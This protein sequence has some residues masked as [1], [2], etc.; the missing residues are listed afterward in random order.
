MLG[1][2]DFI[3]LVKNMKKWIQL[4]KNI[5]NMKKYLSFL[6]KKFNFIKK[7]MYLK[8]LLIHLIYFYLFI[9][10]IYNT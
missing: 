5:Q 9:D 10:L 7:L 1:N 2:W 3:I 8:D 6:S 4:L